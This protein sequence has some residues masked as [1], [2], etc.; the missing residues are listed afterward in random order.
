MRFLTLEKGQSVTLELA[1]GRLCEVIFIG[2]PRSNSVKFAFDCPDDVII[3]RLPQEGIQDGG[4]SM[5][6]H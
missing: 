4:Q 2:K 5:T 1:D 3:Q 6:A